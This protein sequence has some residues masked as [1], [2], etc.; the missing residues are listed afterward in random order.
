MEETLNLFDDRERQDIWELP[1]SK[2]PFL[3]SL[4]WYKTLD[5]FDNGRGGFDL[6][7][8]HLE[9]VFNTLLP[10]EQ[11]EIARRAKVEDKYECDGVF[12]E[13]VLRQMFVSLQMNLTPH[14]VV[15]DAKSHPDF[16]AC[17]GDKSCYVE[18]VVTGQERGPFTL[19]KNEENVVKMLNEDLSSTEFQIG[20]QMEGKLKTT[21]G[22]K[23]K[24]KVVDP[25]AELLKSHSYAEVKELQDTLGLRGTPCQEIEHGDWK[26]TG[27]LIPRTVI[28]ETPCQDIVIKSFIGKCLTES[29]KAVRER[30]RQKAK[31]YKDLD[32]PLVVAVSSR[33]MFFPG[34]G[35][36]VDAL[37]GSEYIHYEDLD[38]RPQKGRRN[39]GVMS[40]YSRITGVL[41]CKG[42]NIWNITRAT[43]RLYVNPFSNNVS[44]LP[45]SLYRLPFYKEKRSQRKEIT[46][47]CRDGL[48]LAQ[49]LGLS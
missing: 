9:S 17:E 20:I 39:D 35:G 18:A 27:W 33:D 46:M 16:L 37:F 22:K 41:M 7:R 49:L 1:P 32:R 30:I 36:D 5:K 11:Q 28:G 26:L 47:Q 12:F 44:E 23:D 31:K 42:V 8:Q 19:N 14:P 40:Q 2:D 24:G 4:T 25:F 21:L 45:D 43:A 10:K 29:V 48:S 13:L 38:S 15:Q 3:D 6:L 34:L